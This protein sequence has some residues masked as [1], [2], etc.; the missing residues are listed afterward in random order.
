MLY[1]N[2]K[3]NVVSSVFMWMFFT[4][5]YVLFGYDIVKAITEA[6]FLANNPTGVIYYLGLFVPF[7]P[8][9]GLMFWGYKI[10]E[11]TGLVE[12]VGFG[13]SQ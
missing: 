13:G 12:P 1:N 3:A 6:V 5:T 10:L 2:K 9:L 11:D 7:L 4:F 8:L